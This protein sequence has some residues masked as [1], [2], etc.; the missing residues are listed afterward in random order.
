MSRSVMVLS[1]LT[2]GAWSISITP[3]LADAIE[4]NENV[5]TTRIGA[6]VVLGTVILCESGGLQPIVK[7]K[8]KVYSCTENIVPGGRT[9]VTPSDSV[10]FKLE[11]GVYSAV[12]CSEADP[13]K[14]KGDTGDT[15]ATQMTGDFGL[16]EVNTGDNISTEVTPYNPTPGQPG[17]GKMGTEVL[18]YN[19]TSDVAPVPGRVPEVSSLLLLGTC[20]AVLA[21]QALWKC[22]A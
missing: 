12:F 6:T 14:L 19:L 21:F 15:C 2:A 16:F 5:T 8:D 13:I 1:L 17:Y 9:Q 22:R 20:V 4:L 3:G 10:T 18:T 11:G 7:V